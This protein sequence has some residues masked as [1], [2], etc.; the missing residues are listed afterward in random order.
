MNDKLKHR[1]KWMFYNWRFV[2]FMVLFATL[3]INGSLGLAET[4]IKFGSY[5][6][7]YLVGSWFIYN[8]K[9]VWKKGDGNE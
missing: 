5:F 4:L 8:V 9:F 3:A 2:G 7:G 6:V 1:I